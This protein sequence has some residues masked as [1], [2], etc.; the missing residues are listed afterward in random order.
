M[1]RVEILGSRISNLEPHEALGLLEA[2]VTDGT[3]GYV[4][5]C[6][7][8]TTVEGYR[9]PTFRDV[10]NRA[11]LAVPD[12]MPL[13][14]ALRALGDGPRR[15]SNGPYLMQTLLERAPTTGHRHFLF[16]GSDQTLDKLLARYGG[17]HIAG[18]FS[19]PFRP[20]TPEE[21]AEHAARINAARPDFVW[22]GLGA[23]KQERWMARLRPQLDAPVLL[24]V[25]AAFA[26]LAGETS[27][28]PRWMQD[29]GLEWA[30]RLG[31]EPKR[32]WKR[33]LTTNPVFVGAFARQ[34]LRER[35]LKRSRP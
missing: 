1:D 5:V 26:M 8:H 22:V 9:D 34:W 25:G 30:F 10:T 29:R 3:R 19:P 16:G 14:W 6:N 17:P 12:G 33:Y 15:R 35:V 28:A 7:V 18:V 24:G 13:V 31:S 32:L 4:C 2:A 11:W 23:P 21:D 27:Q 20:P